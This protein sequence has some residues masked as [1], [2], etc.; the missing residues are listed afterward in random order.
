MPMRC[1]CSLVIL[2]VS[3]TVLFPLVY[4]YRTVALLSPHPGKKEAVS[5]SAV[6]VVFNDNWNQHNASRATR[7]DKV[8]ATVNSAPQCNA[9]GGA[10]TLAGTQD[11]ISRAQRTLTITSRA[12]ASSCEEL[13]NYTIS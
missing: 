9:A 12:V 2:S 7:Y 1:G 11:C 4:Q 8:R 5:S 3:H 6:V 10:S 13:Q